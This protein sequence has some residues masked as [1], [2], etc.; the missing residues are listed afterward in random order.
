MQNLL[1]GESSFVE[2]QFSGKTL[3]SYSAEKRCAFEEKSRLGSTAVQQ[4]AGLKVV[5]ESYPGTRST[6]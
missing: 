1:A 4:S 2:A 3:I 5:L 6:H